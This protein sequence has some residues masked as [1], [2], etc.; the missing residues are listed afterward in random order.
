MEP[1]KT[2]TESAPA[3]LLQVIRCNCKTDSRHSCVT[4]SGSCHWEG[5]KNS[6]EDER[7]IEENENENEYNI[8]EIL[9]PID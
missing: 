9:Q 4:A 6:I 1:V 2:D 3:W 7:E 8:F 5:C